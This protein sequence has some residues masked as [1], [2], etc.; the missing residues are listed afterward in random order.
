MWSDRRE[1]F[2]RITLHGVTLYDPY[3]SLKCC[4]HTEAESL[5]KLVRPIYL[6]WAPYSVQASF[7][8]DHLLHSRNSGALLWVQ[9]IRGKNGHCSRNSPQMRSVSSCYAEE[10]FLV[11]LLIPSPFLGRVRCLKRSM[12]PTSLSQLCT[13]LTSQYRGLHS[14]PSQRHLSSRNTCFSRPHILNGRNR[15]LLRQRRVYLYTG[16]QTLNSARNSF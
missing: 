12:H 7:L 4:P 8:R 1:E 15:I 2:E 5:A 13:C 11:M 14:V 9:F 6:A 10:Y 3:E 16:V